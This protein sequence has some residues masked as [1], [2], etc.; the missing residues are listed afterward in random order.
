M[1]VSIHR[2]IWR[3]RNFAYTILAALAISVGQ[4]WILY[5][6]ANSAPLERDAPGLNASAP[7]DMTINPDEPLPANGT[8]V[9]S[10]AGISDTDMNE[11]VPAGVSVIIQSDKVTVTNQPVS[12]GETAAAA[13]TTVES[14]DDD[15]EE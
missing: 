6:N 7:L 13:E 11:M 9:M 12:V 1:F 10:M 14:S 15:E 4:A 5:Q 2:M 3:S 8:V